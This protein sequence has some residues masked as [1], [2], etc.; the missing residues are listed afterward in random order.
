MCKTCVKVVYEVPQKSRW[1]FNR[2]FSTMSSFFTQIFFYLCKCTFYNSCLIIIIII[3]KNYKDA[4][5][6]KS[7][8]RWIHARI[9]SLCRNHIRSLSW[10]HFHFL[11]LSRHH[12]LHWQCLLVSVYVSTLIFFKGT[13]NLRFFLF[14]LYTWS[15]FKSISVLLNL[16]NHS[17]HQL[18]WGS[19]N[20]LLF[21]Q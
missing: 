6:E 4:T 2:S 18:L 8:C 1:N 5:K 7:R 9:D 14:Y 13:R 10:C 20:N 16:I 3:L 17:T 19:E 15:N 12:L 21:Y 11:F